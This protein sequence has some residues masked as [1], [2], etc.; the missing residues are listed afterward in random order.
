MSLILHKNI[1]FRACGLRKHL[2][3]FQGALLG[4]PAGSEITH[5]VETQPL[6]YP[7]ASEQSAGAAEFDQNHSEEIALTVVSMLGVESGTATSKL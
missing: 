3:L 2:F 7:T 6:S 4:T 5:R 1:F